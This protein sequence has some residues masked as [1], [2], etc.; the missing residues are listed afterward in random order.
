MAETYTPRFRVG[1]SFDMWDRATKCCLCGY[2][3][4]DKR[5]RWVMVCRCPAF[6][7]KKPR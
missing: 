3:Q 6:T 1:S 4:E 5:Y 2:P 7:P